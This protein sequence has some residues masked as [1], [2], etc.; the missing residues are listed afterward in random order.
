MLH[1][2]IPF[3]L[4]AL[5][6]L[7]V[8]IGGMGITLIFGPKRIYS[9][10][11]YEPYECGV[12]QVDDPHRPFSIKFYTFALLFILFDIETIFLLPWALTFK[13]YFSV[14][15]LLD[16]VFFLSVLGLGLYYIIKSKALEWE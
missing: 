6:A 12:D 10:A 7:M 2:Y 9:K 14:G 11:K 8:G 16:G 3:I 4:A 13:Q 5:L 1:D 15:T